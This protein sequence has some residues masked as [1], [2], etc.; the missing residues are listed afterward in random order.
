M[1]VRSQQRAGGF[2]LIELIITIVI[3]A[4]GATLLFSSLSTVLKNSQLPAEMVQAEFLA[5]E[6]AELALAAGYDNV[7]ASAAGSYQGLSWSQA[8][9]TTVTA[10]SGGCP[11]S[12]AVCKSVT[13]TVTANGQGRAVQT[14]LMIKES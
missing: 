13:I 9:P 4:I 10:G 3:S 14:I 7:T 1:M 6:R 2:T 8:A 5:R 11:A 12:G